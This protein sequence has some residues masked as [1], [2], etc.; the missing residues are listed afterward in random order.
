[1]L[2]QLEAT[3]DHIKTQI[4]EHKHS[5]E[6]NEA[7]TC[8][9]LI[10]PL[11]ESLGWNTRDAN[12]V[13]TEYQ[14]LIGGKKSGQFVDYALFLDNKPAIV[15]EAKSLNSPLESVRFFRQ[16]HDYFV[17]TRANVGILTNGTE[18]RFYSDIKN[19]NVMDDTPFVSIDITNLSA[20][21]RDI[22]M[23]FSMDKFNLQDAIDLSEER[24]YLGKIRARLVSAYIRP[25]ESFV[26]W[27]MGETYRGSRRGKKKK[28]WFATLVKEALK[29]FSIAEGT[30]NSVERD[31]TPLPPE[32]IGG[33]TSLSDFK[34]VP[35]TKAPQTMRFPN[36]E[37]RSVKNWRWL[38]I[39]VAEW[40]AREDLLNAAIC[41]VVATHKGS[42]FAHTD[43]FHD[44]QKPFRS[45]HEVGK[46]VFVPTHGSAAA[47]VDRSRR[48]LERFSQDP[49]PGVAE[50]GLTELAGRILEN[51]SGQSG[52]IFRRLQSSPK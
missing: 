11:L 30:S 24:L 20:R 33:W 44:N 6:A 34:V 21:D 25:D 1:M 7:Q 32:N 31:E 27:L 48:L 10:E 50:D 52:F 38:F 12:Q 8:R 49:C 5:L 14:G 3:I 2:D 9:S 22:L 19:A 13:K 16:L 41:P 45:P 42:Y 4:E 39:E 26:N 29:D 36:G 23:C 43:P 17:Y 46:G 35:H 37:E 28:E 51:C 15:L 40:L 18:Y 47:M